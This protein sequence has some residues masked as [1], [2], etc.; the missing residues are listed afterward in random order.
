MRNSLI[1][2]LNCNVASLIKIDEKFK[3]ITFDMRS[4]ANAEVIS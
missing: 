1:T 2:W 3:K 4:E